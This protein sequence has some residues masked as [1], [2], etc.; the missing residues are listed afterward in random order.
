VF[1]GFTVAAMILVSTPG[2]WSAVY[3]FLDHAD[4]NGWTPTDLVFPF[5]LFAMGA[6]VPVALARRRDDSRRVHRHVIR[7]AIVLFCLGLL[8]NAI[9]AS[10]PL[11]LSTF[12]ILGVLQRIA[13][14][15]VAVAWLTER[16]SRIT[17]AIVGVVS[18]VGYWAAMMLVPVPGIGAGVLTPEGNLASFIDRALLGAHLAYPTWE[19]EGLLSTIPAVATALGGVFAGDWLTRARA[20]RHRSASL[21]LFGVAVTALGLLWG[22]VFPVNKNLWTSSFA[23]FSAGMATQLLAV[24]HWALDVHRWRGWSTPFVSFGRN[25]L[26]AYFLS[27]GLDSLLT[28]WPIDA[29]AGASVKWDLY[30]YGFGSWVSQC[31]SAKAASLAYAVTYTALWGLVVTLMYRRRLFIGI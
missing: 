25:A 7:R 13:L 17:Q 24:C 27:V 3:W 2:D 9:E 18:L 30:W 8:L 29:Q 10:S 21:F 6:A 31:C 11:R 20:A 12:R 23:L 1:R 19:P 16:T 15:Y 5:L 4:W 28:R 22:Q 14:V 26:A